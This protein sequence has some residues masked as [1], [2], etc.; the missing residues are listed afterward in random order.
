MH[1]GISSIYPLRRNAFNHNS[2]L[3]KKA[4]QWQFEQF[5]PEGSWRI[6]WILFFAL[7]LRCRPGPGLTGPRLKVLQPWDDSTRVAEDLR[8]GKGVFFIP[9]MAFLIQHVSWF[10]L[11]SLSI[12][13][14]RNF[15]CDKFY[16]KVF[17]GLKVKMQPHRRSKTLATRV[18]GVRALSL[19]QEEMRGWGRRQ[20]CGSTFVSY[21]VLCLIICMRTHNCFHWGVV[22]QV[23]RQHHL[24]VGERTLKRRL[25]TRSLPSI[26]RLEFKPVGFGCQ[27]SFV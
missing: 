16:R 14:L 9:Y 11:G 12:T 3:V 26:P 10:L 15:S 8:G 7:R 13:I 25:P 20:R 19:F 6:V 18:R 22:F 27:R 21:R 1:L 17:D 4:K 2:Q 23:W 24:M 5:L